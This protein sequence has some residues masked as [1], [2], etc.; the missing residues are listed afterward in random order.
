MTV[1]PSGADVAARL[2]AGL[3]HFTAALTIDD[4]NEAAHDL[5]ATAPGRLIGRGPL[6]AF[7]DRRA[8]ELIEL[9][10]RTG[11]AAAELTIR[12]GGARTVVAQAWDDGEAGV[13][14]LLN[15]VSELRR[16]QRIRT[17]FIDNLSH[18][19]RT[20]LSS[21]S[22]LAETLAAET[23]ARADTIPARIRDR[24]AKI[25]VE[26]G[27]L[28]QMVDELLDLSRI[29][30][31]EPMRMDDSV[32]IGLLASEAARRLAPFAERQDVAVSVEVAGDL[33]MLRGNEQRLGQVLLNLVHNAVKFSPD[34][35]EVTIRVRRDAGDVVAAVEDHGIG[36]ARN[37]LPRIFER[38][39]KADRARIRGGGTGLGLAI[40]RHIVEAHDGTITATS[41]VG[42]GS[43]FTVRLPIEAALDQ[44]GGHG[45][46]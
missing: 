24:V 11:S 14:L 19:L 29:E 8:E 46:R 43:T 45:D 10:Q 20:P 7:L 25:E 34:G 30:S 22:L 37:D 27:H 1:A 6:E 5:L 39:Y 18:E 4:A 28:V 36:I 26:T 38:F 2:G 13:W 35:G 15:D 16:L 3:V 17:E 44:P 32:D 42:L 12:D 31:G 21:I 33:P 9:A 40:A 23:R 41:D